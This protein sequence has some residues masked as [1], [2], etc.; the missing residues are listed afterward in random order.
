M[1]DKGSDH[2]NLTMSAHLKYLHLMVTVLV[3]VDQVD[4]ELL[5]HLVT[6]GQMAMEDQIQL[7]LLVEMQDQLQLSMLV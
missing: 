6:T 5:H 2:H 7:S 1:G 3:L 4:L